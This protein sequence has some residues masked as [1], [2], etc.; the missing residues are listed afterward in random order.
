M[1]ERADSEGRCGHEGSE[2]RCEHEDSGGRHQH[3]D[4]KGRHQHDNSEGTSDMPYSGS[5]A[6]YLLTKWL[7]M[8][9]TATAWRCESTCGTQLYRAPGRLEDTAFEL[10][11]CIIDLWQ[12]RVQE[13]LGTRRARMH[14]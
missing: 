11:R 4:S 10:R 5:L 2:G 8:S 1:D 14:R 13:S 9:M 6:M 7:I 12:I 3:E